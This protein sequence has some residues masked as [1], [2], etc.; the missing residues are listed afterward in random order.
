M[1]YRMLSVRLQFVTVAVCYKLLAYS[2]EYACN[3]LQP[4]PIQA[5]LAYKKTRRR[6]SHEWIP[7]KAPRLYVY[8][9]VRK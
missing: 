1:C 9:S 7:F 2:A 3:L 4:L 5:L 8:M 6:N